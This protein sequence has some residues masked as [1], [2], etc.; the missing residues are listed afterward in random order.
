MAA[1]FEIQVAP[2]LVNE[3]ITV[4]E[5]FTPTNLYV[6]FGDTSLDAKHINVD[7]ILFD[8]LPA[9]DIFTTLDRRMTGMLVIS[10]AELDGFFDEDSSPNI[11]AINTFLSQL[12]LQYV[13]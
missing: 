2:L 11:T 4:P 8:K 6:K 9:N 3:T 5:W 13:E 12:N 1:S 7:F 10:L